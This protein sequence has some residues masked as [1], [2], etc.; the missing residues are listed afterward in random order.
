MILVLVTTSGRTN[1]GQLGSK[2]RKPASVSKLSTFI[3]SRHEFKL[4]N[5]FIELA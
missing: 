1:V 3:K 2:C 5:G 4:S